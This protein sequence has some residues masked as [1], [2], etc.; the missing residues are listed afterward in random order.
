MGKPINKHTK[1]F[2]ELLKGLK[3][4]SD[5]FDAFEQEALE[6]FALLENKE[7]AIELKNHLDERMEKEVLVKKRKPLFIYWSAA[8]GIALLAGL[9]FIFNN[10]SSFEKQDLAQNTTIEEK[11][12]NL[13]G[14]SVPSGEIDKL[15]DVNPT[16]KATTDVESDRRSS[17][18]S[19]AESGKEEAFKQTE[20]SQS[21]LAEDEVQAPAPPAEEQNDSRD[22]NREGEREGKRSDLDDAK[23]TQQTPPQSASNF[24]SGAGASDNNKKNAVT[25][26]KDKEQDSKSD[27]GVNS[28][29]IKKEKPKDAPGKSAEPAAQ[30]IKT[31][32]EIEGP[33][34]KSN[35]KPA[36][37]TIKESDLNNQITKFLSDKSYKKSFI[38]TLT[39]NNANEVEEVTF[40]KEDLFKRSELKELKAFFKKLKC[41]KNNEYALYSTYKINYISE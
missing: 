39:I 11:S 26:S 31:K 17:K 14:K 28:R 20:N 5:D 24:A 6:G 2:D 36:T 22:Q 30:E 4:P 8:A 34:E 13:E 12:K 38:C 27:E 9:I 15:E 23:K 3:N 40:G 10:T 25:P 29:K 21:T 33:F 16:P 35:I 7:E 32:S 19:R 1:N 37:L 41:F 18:I